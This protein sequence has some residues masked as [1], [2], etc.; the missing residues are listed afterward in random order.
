VFQYFSALKPWNLIPLKAPFWKNY[1]LKKWTSSISFIFTADVLLSVLKKVAF[2]ESRKTM[3]NG[4]RPKFPVL[5]FLSIR[6]FTFFDTKTPKLLKTSIDDWYLRS[7]LSTDR[8]QK[9]RDYLRLR[10]RIRRW[11]MSENSDFQLSEQK[12]KTI[13]F[14]KLTQHIT[15]WTFWEV[16]WAERKFVDAL[17]SP[18]I[19]WPWTMFGYFANRMPYAPYTDGLTGK[20]GRGTG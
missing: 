13:F 19:F 17:L 18:Q 4:G 9:V 2:T 14:L 3:A 20:H 12:W 7:N 6:R 16:N 1:P 11:I 5:K 8:S 10:P 15:N